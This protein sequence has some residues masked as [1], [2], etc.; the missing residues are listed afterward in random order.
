MYF[1][2]LLKCVDGSFYT[3]VAADYQKRFHEHK[4]GKGGRYTR[5]HKPEKLV[6]VERFETEMEALQRE[7]QIKGWRREKKENLIRHGKPMPA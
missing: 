2:Y 5:L 3:G 4:E 6:Y 7:R 1:V